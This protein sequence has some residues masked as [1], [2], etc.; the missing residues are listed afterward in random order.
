M[1]YFEIMAI[2]LPMQ[3]V[4]HEIARPQVHG[5][6]MTCLTMLGRYRFA[7]GADEKVARIFEAPR[8]FLENLVSLCSVDIKAAYDGKVRIKI[9]YLITLENSQKE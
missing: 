3:R 5:Y 8:N 1:Y 6:D 2:R 7:S 9:L 4:W